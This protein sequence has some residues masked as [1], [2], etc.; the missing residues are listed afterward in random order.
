MNQPGAVLFSLN[1]CERKTLRSQIRGQ[2]SAGRAYGQP[3]GSGAGNKLIPTRR[4]NP[5]AGQNGSVASQHH[6]PLASGCSKVNILKQQREAVHYNKRRG[7]HSEC[8][9]KLVKMERNP[10]IGNT[11]AMESASDFDMKCTRSGFSIQ[12]LTADV[13]LEVFPI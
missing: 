2:D 1:D 7:Q 4:N 10:V 12:K 3:E 8:P 11:F 6:L 9:A 5:T 13:V